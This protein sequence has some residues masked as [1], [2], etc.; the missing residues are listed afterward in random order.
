[1]NSSGVTYYPWGT[2]FET[3]IIFIMFV[4]VFV[5]A[6]QYIDVSMGYCLREVVK[7]LFLYSFL[8][9]HASLH[10]FNYSLRRL[11]KNFIFCHIV[12]KFFSY[13]VVCVVGVDVS[14]S[15]L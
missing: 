13:T 10:I 11:C 7:L 12:I 8:L 3:M 14:L 1:M 15:K 2:C 6:R 5:L 4:R 9:R